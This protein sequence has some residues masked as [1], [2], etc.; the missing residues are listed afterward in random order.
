MQLEWHGWDI[1]AVSSEPNRAPAGDA[2]TGMLAERRSTNIAAG[3]AAPATIKSGELALN[4]NSTD[5]GVHIGA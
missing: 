5:V 3:S 4:S 2:V 1:H